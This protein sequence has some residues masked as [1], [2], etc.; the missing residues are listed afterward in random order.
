MD[1][2]RTAALTT[3][4][5]RGVVAAVGLGACQ[6]V[7]AVQGEEFSCG[8]PSCARVNGDVWCWGNNGNGEQSNVPV[9]VSAWAP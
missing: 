5:L 8:G 2:R 3:L 6:L 9:P 4:L 1:S 7:T